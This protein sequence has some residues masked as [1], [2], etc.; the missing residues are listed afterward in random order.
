M[1]NKIILQFKSAGQDIVTNYIQKTQ[2]ESGY[3]VIFGTNIQTRFRYND[4]LD[5]LKVSIHQNRTHPDQE[6][7]SSK[8]IHKFIISRLSFMSK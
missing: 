1:L 5:F 8:P 2:T 4:Y 6:W 7:P 3:I